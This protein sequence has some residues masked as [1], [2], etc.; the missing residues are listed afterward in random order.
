VQNGWSRENIGNHIV[1]NNHISHC[2]QA[3]IAGSL[4]AIFSSITGNV[5]HD[6]HV[7]RLFGGH[8]MA[9]IKIHGA[10]DSYISHNHIYRTVRGIWLDWMTQGTRVTGNLLYD[11]GPHADFFIEVNHG[12]FVIDNNISLSAWSLDDWSQGGTYAH[13]LFGGRM[14]F[15][16]VPDRS[17]PYHQ[18]HSTV[19]A[20]LSNI[21]G[22]DNNFYNNIVA[23]GSLA[24]YDDAPMPSRMAGN[25]FLGSAV[26]SA[27]EPE[28][29]I[30]PYFDPDIMLAVENNDVFLQIAL[31]NS[32]VTGD[33]VLVVTEMLG[34]TAVSGLH[35]LNFDANPLT[36]DTDY[37]GKQR[38]NKNPY[39]G[40]FGAPEEGINRFRVW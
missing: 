23:G 18:P 13:N 37:S 21:P 9:G 32:F 6:I 19:V 24:I 2:E 11:N 29:V 20:G 26:P 38:N 1:R 36:V 30:K 39:P 3:G 34:K 10:I 4:G 40:P 14:A 31:D 8:E 33:N 17:T 15:R 22:G 12:P 28:P 25:V 27:L 5:I 7:R 16:P 35:F